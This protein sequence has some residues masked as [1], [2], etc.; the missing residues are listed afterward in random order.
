MAR[1]A[2]LGGSLSPYHL[3]ASL[4]LATAWA[5]A[6]PAGLPAPRLP[7]L[8]ILSIFRDEAQGLH[9]WLLHYAAEG[10]RQFV[11]LDQESTD[12]GTHTALAFAEKHPRVDITVIPAVGNYQQ[13]LL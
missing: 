6:P 9:E 11:L 10:V 13:A 7:T 12:N 8:G 5:A 3:I 4:I 2:L 1:I